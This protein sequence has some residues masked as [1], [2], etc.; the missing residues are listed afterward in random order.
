MVLIDTHLHLNDKRFQ[1]DVRE[2]IE[3][4]QGAGIKH[5][6][7]VGSDVFSSKLAV[8]Q[9][10]DYCGVYAAVGIHPH[11]ASSSNDETLTELIELLPN[12]KVVAWGEIGLDYHYDFSPRS[13]QRESFITQLDIAEMYKYPVIIHNRESHEDMIKILNSRQKP[14]TGVMH[15]FSGSVEMAKQIL[16]LGMYISLA[17]PL[18]F[19]N[20]RK[21][22]DVVKFVPLDRL[23][24]ETDSPYLAPV[25]YRG[26]RNEPVYVLEVA[27]KI[28]QIKGIELDAVASNTTE[29]AYKLF[30]LDEK[31]NA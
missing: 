31:I 20:A 14:I 1:G 27:K 19:K 13:K 21:L 25:P 23:L 22:P 26:K 10:N 29:N 16:D 18:T 15:C 8:K 12:K 28:A 17:G 2:V 5:M 6:I 24:I 11:S 9:A 3:R 4:A 30:R 7:N